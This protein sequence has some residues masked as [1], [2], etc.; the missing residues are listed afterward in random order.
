MPGGFCWRG[1]SL[2]T[3]ARKITGVS[4]NGPRFCGLRSRKKPETGWIR[5]IRPRRSLV[6][7]APPKRQR[8]PIYQLVTDSE[9]EE[10]AMEAILI[11]FSP[12]TAPRKG[13]RSSSRAEGNTLCASR[14]YETAWLTTQQC[15]NPSRPQIPCEQGKY[16]EIFRNQA[17][18]APF[19]ALSAQ[20][21]HDSSR[22]S[23]FDKTGKRRIDNRGS[24]ARDQGG[25][26]AGTGR[27]VIEQA[28]NRATPLD[29]RR[30]TRS[31]ERRKPD[32]P[33]A[34]CRFCSRSF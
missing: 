25:G 31:C 5:R 15:A 34:R 22:N 12:P 20:Q 7:H 19:L 30:W 26:R 1:E 6:K 2:S 27:A 4:W 9:Q 14:D 24:H 33:L 11:P 32:P 10:A 29:W 17:A 21:I 18:S 16:R 8:C 28:D 13:G 23:L 3:I